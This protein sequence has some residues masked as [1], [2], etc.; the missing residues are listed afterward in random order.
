VIPLAVSVL[1]SLAWLLTA[2][3]LYARWRGRAVGRREC[4]THGSPDKRSRSYPPV[5]CCYDETTESDGLAA[6]WAM[7]AA[8][9]WPA[10][11]AVAV[12]RFRPPLTEIEKAGRKKLTGELERELGIGGES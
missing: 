10:V 12:V 5:Q 4:V 1:Y 8:L 6:A 9:L 3:Q 11:L 2:R 7:G